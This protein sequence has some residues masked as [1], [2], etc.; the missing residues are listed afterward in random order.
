[1]SAR[2]HRAHQKSHSDELYDIETELR[3]LSLRVSALRDGEPHD[4]REPH[5]T[6]HRQHSPRPKATFSLGDKVWLRVYDE[7]RHRYTPI[8][9]TVIGFTPK[10]VRI[11]LPNNPL[12]VLRASSSITHVKY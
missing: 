5:D 4:A 9:G 12:P 10:R 11:R 8:I 6:R 3:A 1:M 2:K 7:Q